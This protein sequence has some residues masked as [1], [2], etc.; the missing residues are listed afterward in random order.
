[1]LAWE[2]ANVRAIYFFDISAIPSAVLPPR[3]QRIKALAKPG[4]SVAGALADSVAM[5]LIV[6]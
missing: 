3:Y 1:M 6:T 4:A 2:V 5:F